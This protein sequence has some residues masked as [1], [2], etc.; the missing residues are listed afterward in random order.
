MHSC[1]LRGGHEASRDSALRR[2]K[3]LCR[4]PGF[5]SPARTLHATRHSFAV[6]YLRRGGLVF[7]LQ[8]FWANSSLEMTRRYANLILTDLQAVHE[9]VE[10]AVQGMKGLTLRAIKIPGPKSPDLRAGVFSMRAA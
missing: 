1:L 9:R 6:T 8:K 10:L 4:K 5:E 2:V 7:H 3:L